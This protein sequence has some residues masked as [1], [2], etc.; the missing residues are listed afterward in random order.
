[1]MEAIRPSETSVLTNATLHHI[2]EDGVARRLLRENLKFYEHR[3]FKN[4]IPGNL[5]QVVTFMIYIM[6]INR[7]RSS[8]RH[9]IYL[10]RF[11]VRSTEKHGEYSGS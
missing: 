3:L 2:P 11:P 1:M 7:L 10:L 8:P 4:Y 5:A 9:R 6:G